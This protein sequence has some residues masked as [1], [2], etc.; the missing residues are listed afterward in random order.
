MLRFWRLFG[1]AQR[2]RKRTLDVRFLWPALV[3]QAP[4]LEAARFAFASHVHND[5][6]WTRDFSE[7]ERDQFVY[8]LET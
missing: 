5:S 8:S 6:A 7:A 4:D 2:L 1:A 3:R